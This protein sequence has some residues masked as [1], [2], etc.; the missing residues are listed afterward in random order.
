MNTWTQHSWT[1]SFR[2]E[3]KT[4]NG[5]VKCLLCPTVTFE[6]PRSHARPTCS[7][8]RQSNSETATRTHQN[9]RSYETI[10]HRHRTRKV[11][12]HVRKCA[13]AMRGSERVYI[14]IYIYIG[15][16][17]AELNGLREGGGGGW[18]PPWRGGGGGGGGESIPKNHPRR[19][20]PP[21]AAPAPRG[22]ATEH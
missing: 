13:Q 5:A 15:V 7:Q 18:G 19:A 14:Y 3:K 17:N 10:N 16:L 20:P 22:E 6:S 11:G 1:S 21:E 2:L 12:I 8:R 9:E 4:R